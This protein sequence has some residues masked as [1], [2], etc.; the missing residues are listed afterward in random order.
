[1]SSGIGRKAVSPWT[2]RRALRDRG[3]GEQSLLLCLY[4]I[5]TYMD[6]DGYAYPGQESIAAGMR[7]SVRTVRRLIDAAA[8]MG[9]LHVEEFKVTGKGWRRN[10]YR[11]TVP[12]H[13]DLEEMDENLRDV[14]VSQVG[15]V[16]DE[17]SAHGADTRMAAPTATEEPAP[18]V[19]LQLPRRAAMMVSAPVTRVRD[20]CVTRALHD[21]ADISP[22]GADIRDA[23]CGQAGG[24]MVRTQLWPMKYS[25]EVVSSRSSQ[26]EG[27]LA[28]SARSPRN[29]D[30]AKAEE[31]ITRIKPGVR[32]KR[33]RS[34]EQPA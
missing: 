29:A 2:W 34:G 5:G 16:D 7:A 25:V 22:L 15:D 12:L 20:A 31:R 26:Y 6:R 32:S 1:V 19:A 24:Q 27:P 4:T 11:C 28:R 14:I 33:L 10:S 3:P 18:H 13:L 21:G 9:W 23:W 17:E 30:E 8:R